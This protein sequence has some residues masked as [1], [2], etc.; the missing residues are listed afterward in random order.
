M[1]R[2]RPG[3]AED[4]PALLA[5]LPGLA[6]FPL[7]AWRTARQIAEADTRILLDALH[8]PDPSTLVLVAEADGGEA[9]GFI[10]ATT[11][12]DY[13]TGA[14][15]AHIEVLVVRDSARGQGL[16]R[17]LIG[18]AEEWARG[19]GYAG[20]TLNVF[21]ANQRAAAL[22]RRQGYA[23]ETVHYIK[24]LDAAATRG[25]PDP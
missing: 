22:Y 15:H 6:D 11:R 10:F 12:Q 1:T 8:R 24:P 13:F 14:P 2:L 18:A 23:P 4:T 5:L 3:R 17:T 21:D 20:I 25:E 19:R 7:P 9:A 16:A